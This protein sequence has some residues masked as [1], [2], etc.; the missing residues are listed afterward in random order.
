MEACSGVSC[1]AVSLPICPKEL[2]PDAQT[3]R[4]F[5]TMRLWELPAQKSR[6][7]RGHW[8]GAGMIFQS[9][10]PSCPNSLR[11][12]C[13]EAAPSFEEKGVRPACGNLDYP[14]V[15]DDSAFAVGCR[16]VAELAV[17]V[18][19]VSAKAAV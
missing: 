7:S 12:R 3:P 16:P 4:A 9:P 15:N 14:A 1:Q 17:V 2:E 19:P 10:S 13:V 8:G 11:H 6:D 5:L 18:T